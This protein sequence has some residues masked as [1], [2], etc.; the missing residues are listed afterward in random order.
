MKYIT[1]KRLINDRV[2]KKKKIKKKLLNELN[3]FYLFTHF[4]KERKSF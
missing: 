3:L 1:Q 2:Y 4:I